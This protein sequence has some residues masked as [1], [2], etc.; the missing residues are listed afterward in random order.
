MFRERKREKALPT[1]KSS[2]PS[3][4]CARRAGREEDTSACCITEAESVRCREFA[5]RVAEG[6]CVGLLMEDNVGC[7]AGG[8]GGVGD[9]KGI[10]SIR[11][12]SYS[13]A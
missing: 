4:S 10:S 12:Q 9:K 5:R 1:S 13:I 8:G 3:A 7:D 6:E 11:C 2:G